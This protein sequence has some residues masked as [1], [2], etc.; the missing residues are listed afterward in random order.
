MFQKSDYSPLDHA[1]E[2]GADQL[3]LQLDGWLDALDLRTRE[4]REHIFRVTNATISLA[5]MAGVPEKE[6]VHIR[7]GALLHDIGNIGIPD[8]ILLKADKLTTEER[9]IV[10]KH[11]V[12]AHDLFYPIEYLKNCLSIPYSHHEK[13]DGTGYPLGLKGE[14]IPLAARLFAIVDVWDRLS[15]DRVYGRAWPQEKVTKYILQQSGCHFDPGVVDMFFH[16]QRELAAFDRG[17]DRWIL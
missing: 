9:E 12:Y 11:P 14:Q 15:C 13:W 10:R 8:A 5:R 3:D 6:I 17:S 16:A 7:N 4:T 1:T 2:I